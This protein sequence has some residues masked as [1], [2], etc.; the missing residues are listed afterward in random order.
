MSQTEV[1]SQQQ[2][3]NVLVSAAQ[4]AQ[5]RGVFNLDE[6]AVIAQA[7]NVFMP[8]PPPEEEPTQ[9]DF[10]SEAEDASEES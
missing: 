10:S 8:P 2:A 1:E 3:L 4:V 7:V 9:E 6:A 5:K